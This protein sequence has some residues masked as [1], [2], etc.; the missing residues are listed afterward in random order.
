MQPLR[1]RVLI[2]D[3]HAP[4]LQTLREVLSLDPS[5]CIVAECSDGQSA[6][7]RLLGEGLDLAIL[8]VEMPGLD[9]IAVCGRLGSPPQATPVIVLTLHKEP[10]LQRRARE[11]GVRGYVLKEYAVLDVLPAVHAV[12]AGRL[13]AGRQCTGFAEIENSH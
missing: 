5:V 11:A 1:I 2:A 8:D 7:A 6:L 3:D 12:L 9:G 4:F 13:Y 10:E